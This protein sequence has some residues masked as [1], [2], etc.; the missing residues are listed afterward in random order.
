MENRFGARG[1]C[2]EAALRN[3]RSRCRPLDTRM[4]YGYSKGRDWL[5]GRGVT[6][7]QWYDCPERSCSRFP[8]YGID[9][10]RGFFLHNREDPTVPPTCVTRN[11][12]REYVLR[13]LIAVRELELDVLANWTGFER[14][15]QLVD[16]DDHLISVFTSEVDAQYQKLN[17]L[18][19]PDRWV[20][21][22]D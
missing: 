17:Q 8:L 18:S 13:V 1:Q 15:F 22:Y 10:P 12:K 3:V 21:L 20:G 19:E 4:F 7:E 5:F 6:F 16:F 9:L 2:A 14:D 11:R